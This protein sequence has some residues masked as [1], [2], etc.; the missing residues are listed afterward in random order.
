MERRTVFLMG[1]FDRVIL[2][3][4]TFFFTALCVIYSA[5]MLGW[6]APVYLL[7]D[8]FYP[9]QPEV[10][11]SLMVGLILVGGRLF[12][13]SLRKPRGR[14]V[15]LAESTLGQIK[16]SLQ[17][18]ENLVEKVVSQINGVREVKARIFSTPQGVGI[19]IRASV[20]PD[21]NVP[22]VSVEIQNRVKE[23]VFE[24]TGIS[25]SAVKVSIENITVQKPRV[26]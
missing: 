13:V 7:R 16:L 21:V 23:R 2:A 24:V 11:W 4:Y 25:V 8:I 15:V 19:R 3:V 5:A 12:W 20:T 17:A 26:E 22:E 9:G 1:S 14:H 10:F 6:P 18:I